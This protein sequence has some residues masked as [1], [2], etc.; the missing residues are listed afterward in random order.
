VFLSGRRAIAPLIIVSWVKETTLFQFLMDI[1]PVES[2]YQ[3]MAMAIYDKN[4]VKGDITSIPSLNNLTTPPSSERDHFP[5]TNLMSVNRVSVDRELLLELYMQAS[6]PTSKA[7]LLTI[8]SQ[9]GS[10][11]TTLKPTMNPV[12]T[13]NGRGAPSG[14]S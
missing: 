12:A 1:M 2:T 13:Q 8:L 9:E 10:A 14:G 7:T 11:Q 6:L 5:Q 4:Q 3:D